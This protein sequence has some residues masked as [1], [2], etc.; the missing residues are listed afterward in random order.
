MQLL[1]HFNGQ[2]ANRL[3]C[4]SLN[5][6]LLYAATPGQTHGNKQGHMKKKVTGKKVEEK[7]E[8]VMGGKNMAFNQESSNE[9][10]G[11]PQERWLAMWERG[12]GLFLW[13]HMIG[14]LISAQLCPCNAT[15]QQPGCQ[16]TQSSFTESVMRCFFWWTSP[17]F[18]VSTCPLSRWSVRGSALWSYWC[19][20]RWWPRLCTVIQHMA[21]S[22]AS[23]L[24]KCVRDKT[25]MTISGWNKTNDGSI[26]C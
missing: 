23:G 22:T 9:G 25:K 3:I 14:S 13:A 19:E 11:K 24:R 7:E 18:S 16:Q 4:E 2:Q 8:E 5:V 17:P 1:S 20:C 12:W 10:I 21:Q 15:D 6:W 26:G